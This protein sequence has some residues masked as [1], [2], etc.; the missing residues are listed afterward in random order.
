MIQPTKNRAIAVSATTL[1]VLIQFS[2]IV[3]VFDLFFFFAQRK[4]QKKN[5]I[6]C[7]ISNCG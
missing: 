7:R 5:K 6:F 2:A 4:W 1:A 3:F